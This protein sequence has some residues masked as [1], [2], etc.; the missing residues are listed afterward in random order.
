MK[1][2]LAFIFLFF[3]ISNSSK[4][5]TDSYSSNIFTDSPIALSSGHYSFNLPLFNM[6]TSS[7][8]INLKAQLSYHSKSTRAIYSGSMFGNGFSLNVL[9]VISRDNATDETVL[10]NLTIGA[11]GTNPNPDVY[12]YNVYGLSGKFFVYVKN[13]A[14]QVQLLEQN[15]YAQ[16]KVKHNNTGFNV[17][18]YQ[19]MYFTIIDKNGTEYIFSTKETRTDQY[20]SQNRFLNIYLTNVIDKSKKEILNY[21]YSDRTVG[22]NTLKQI[23]E[24][25][26]PGNGRVKFTIQNTTV[27]YMK[28]I[29]IYNEFNTLEQTIDLG[30]S[31]SHLNTNNLWKI[32]YKDTNNKSYYY[33][34]SYYPNSGTLDNSGF[35]WTGTIANQY[36]PYGVNSFTEFAY[37]SLLTGMTSG[38]LRQVTLP[39]GGTI[40]FTY[41]VNDMKLENND[42]YT[43]VAD[44][45]HFNEIPRTSTNVNV[46]ENGLFVNYKRHTF[47]IAEKAKLFH[48]IRANGS[49][50]YNFSPPLTT[51]PAY[52]ILKV[53]NS[54]PIINTT[55]SSNSANYSFLTL[56]PGTYYLEFRASDE[57]KFTETS[58]KVHTKKTTDLQQFI[59][60]PG[61]RIKSIKEQITGQVK[62]ETVFHYKPLSQLNDKTSSGYAG[63]TN[64]VYSKAVLQYFKDKT[65]EFVYYTTVTKEIKGKGFIEYDYGN[66]ILNDSLLS[67]GK[68]DNLRNFPKTVKRYD[69]NK[70][71]EEEIVNTYN[72]QFTPVEIN[73]NLVNVKSQGIL[74]NQST[75]GK[76][77]INNQNNAN[78]TKD[79]IYSTEYRVPLTETVTDLKS[80]EVTK[81]ESSYQKLG[82]EVLLSDTNKTVN[83]N[84]LFKRTYSYGIQLINTTESFYKL[85]SYT[86]ENKFGEVIS[87]YQVTKTDVNG[88]ILEYLDNLGVYHSIVWGYNN[89]KKLFEISDMRYD[90][91]NQLTIQNLQLY[92]SSQHIG[93]YQNP[94]LI[95]NLYSTLRNTHPDKLI[96]TYTYY[97]NKGLRTVTDP[98]GR[99][100]NYTYDNFRRLLDI[101]DHEGNLIKT[102]QYNFINGVN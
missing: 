48:K 57:S 63:F 54:T 91:I 72:F 90:N 5:Q 40:D 2:L 81:L 21:V 41:E 38:A 20:S 55:A 74:Q 67:V 50:N 22:T 77:Y 69:V 6:E 83:N 29:E 25:L 82:N 86:E 14:L 49:T 12:S 37:P 1:N 44:N 100:T 102:Y 46:I 97:S 16:I 98:N 32:T 36:M 79:I 17:R 35:Y 78:V 19:N 10:P 99:T 87:N 15:D 13:G 58:L 7:S 47:T 89:S 92:S 88:N 23:S 11:N 52:R 94:N 71:L 75:S 39:T 59:Y 9:P 31:P 28:S 3:I 8:L 53:G 4:A 51:Y 64:G 56:D 43:K 73:E 34:L 62:N 68:Y 80:G 95:L 84:L 101:K 27:P 70:N 65:K 26:I 96:T 45:Y 93:S 60:A 18:S 30:Y 61:A 24:I 33:Q 42:L 85:N 76:S 66:K